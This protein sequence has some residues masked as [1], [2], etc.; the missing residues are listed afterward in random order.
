FCG[1]LGWCERSEGRRM[2]VSRHLFLSLC[3]L[4]CS[5]ALWS[6]GS[7]QV[8]PRTA[9]GLQAEKTITVVAF[10]RKSISYDEMVYK[11][12][13]NETNTHVG[14]FEGIWDVEHDFDERWSQSLSKL[15]VRSETATKVVDDETVL[16]HLR[17]ALAS[18]TLD[19][20][21]KVPADVRTALLNKGV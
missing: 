19:N 21:L 9:Q 8:P 7:N 20:E 6:C 1:S 14:S 12:F 16:E 10:D 3:I 5:T 17:D 2:K 13:Y 11:V 4:T 15:G 18:L